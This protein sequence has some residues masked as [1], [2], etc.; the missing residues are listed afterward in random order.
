MPGLLRRRLK[1]T[2]DLVLRLREANRL[3]QCAQRFQ[4]KVHVLWDGCVVDGKSILDLM[5]LGAGAGDL[6]ELEFSGPDSDE[7]AQAFC[8]FV[9][10]LIHDHE[11]GS[12]RFAVSAE[13]PAKRTTVG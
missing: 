1:I 11:N 10:G 8:E 7:A 12:N 6:V 3:V 4:S 2:S 9:E 5:T 13:P